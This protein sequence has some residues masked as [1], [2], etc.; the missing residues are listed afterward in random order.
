[1]NNKKIFI[2]GYV[3]QEQRNNNKS[4][5]PENNSIVGDSPIYCVHDMSVAKEMQTVNFCDDLT[6]FSHVIF[7][8]L[9]LPLSTLNN[10]I[11]LF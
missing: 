11:F 8:F 1:M 7:H 3:T 10:L 2:Y 9:L 4:E 6:I 5:N